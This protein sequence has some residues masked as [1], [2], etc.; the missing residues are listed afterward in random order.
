MISC[1]LAPPHT[2]N[3]VRIFHAPAYLNGDVKVRGV[4]LHKQGMVIPLAI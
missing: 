3:W 2:R 4:T 1:L